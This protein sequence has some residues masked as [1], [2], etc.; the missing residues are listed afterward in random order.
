MTA[1]FSFLK[2]DDW[3]QKRCS[4]AN[5]KKILAEFH[6]PDILSSKTCAKL[7]GYCGSS[8]SFSRDG[9]NAKLDRLSAFFLLVLYIIR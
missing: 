7:N 2:S 5:R 1:C 8:S 4:E 6:A 3:W 9:D